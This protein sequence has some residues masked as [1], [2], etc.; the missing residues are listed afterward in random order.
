MPPAQLDDTTGATHDSESK[1]ISDA[2]FKVGFKNLLY[3]STADKWQ[4][5][6]PTSFY[7]LSA[8]SRPP[9]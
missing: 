1:K 7:T 2:C 5:L 4:R 6:S 3:F 8:Q 9:A